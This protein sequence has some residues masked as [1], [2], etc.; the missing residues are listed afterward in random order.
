MTVDRPLSDRQM[1]ALVMC[2]REFVSY[3]TGVSMP[4][5]VKRGL[6]LDHGRYHVPRGHPRRY[7]ISEA[8]RE[9]VKEHERQ[10]KLTAP[11]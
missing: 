6:V 7:E 4:S 2:G 5:L 10:K 11:R 9:V 3:Y 1:S 8:G